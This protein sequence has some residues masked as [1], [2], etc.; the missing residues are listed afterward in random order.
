M[1][2]FLVSSLSHIS[3][4]QMF[5]FFFGLTGSSLSWMIQYGSHADIGNWYFS[6]QVFV[7]LFCF[8]HPLFSRFPV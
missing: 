1:S 6:T 5:T 4:K 8:M 7:Q 3:F 2:K